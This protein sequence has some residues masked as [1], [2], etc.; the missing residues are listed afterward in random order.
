[1][2]EDEDESSLSLAAM[3]EELKPQ[4][5]ETFK[6][7]TKAHKKLTKIQEER[8]TILETSKE[9]PKRVADNYR[10]ARAELID[11]MQSVRLNVYRSEQLI[12]QLYTM[13]R[14]VMGLEG[15][16]MR[17][18]VS[19]GVS[20]EEFLERWAGNEANQRWMLGVV[21]LP[22]KGCTAITIFLQKL[23]PGHSV[24]AQ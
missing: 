11:L 5:I 18:A 12:E 15:Q 20:R 17:H 14:K 24:V 19:A 21:K 3:E 23:F 9:V 2:V 10:K 6:M 4:I 16:I 22:S 8:N 13:N 1:V 7:I